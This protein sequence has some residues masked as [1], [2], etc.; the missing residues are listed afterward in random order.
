MYLFIDTNKK[1]QIRLI[2]K[3]EASN[4]RIDKEYLIDNK[5]SEDILTYISDFLS[6]NNII[7]KNID[8]VIVVNG[9]GINLNF[10]VGIVITNTIGYLL[11]I[12]I[13][14]ISEEEFKNYEEFIEIGL[15]KIKKEKEYRPVKPIYKY[16]NW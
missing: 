4:F 11:N 1:E 14:G 5:K 9:P 6:K 13:V 7:Y 15:D 16:K 8:G 10:K 12:P 2:L 3:D